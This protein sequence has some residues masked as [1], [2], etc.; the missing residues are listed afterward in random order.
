MKNEKKK[1]K[2]KKRLG[3]MA[4]RYPS[5]QSVLGPCSGFWEARVN[6]RALDD[7]A[8]TLTLLTELSRARKSADTVEIVCLLSFQSHIRLRTRERPQVNI[9]QFKI[10]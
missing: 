5:T 2:E 10:F 4:D 6:G 1:K 3:D 8:T 7:F 9:C